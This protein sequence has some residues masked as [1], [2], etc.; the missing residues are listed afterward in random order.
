MATSTLSTLDP[1]LQDVYLGPLTE[2]F[3]NRTPLYDRVERVVPSQVFNGR[4]VVLASHTGRNQGFGYRPE[5]A[6]LPS[7]KRPDS[8]NMFVDLVYGYGKIKLSGQII[9]AT[10]KGRKAFADALEWNMRDIKE[11]LGF[12]TAKHVVF[13]DGTG[14]MALANGAGTSQTSLIVD[15]PGA[16]LFE[17]EMQ[18][19]V[20]TSGGSQEVNNVE[21]TA[22]NQSTDTLTLGTASTWSDN[23]K[24]YL[25]GERNEVIMGLAGIVD[26]GTR[27]SSFQGVTRSSNT[28]LN[29]NVLSNSGTNR[30]VTLRLVDDGAM[31]GTKNMASS[32]QMPTAIY[33][34][35]V[36]AQNYAELVRVD[37][38]F[39]PNVKT[40]NNGWRALEVEVPGGVLPWFLEPMCR[41]NE[42]F[43]VRES[44][45]FMLE[46]APMGWVDYDGHVTR[47]A[48]DGS[49]ALEACLRVY[50]QLA[51]R[52]CNTHTLIRDVTES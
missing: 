4:R 47:M 34:R 13:G 1:I 50:H 52:R 20:Y 24:V 14:V 40:L 44:D 7:A 9:A 28:W 42:I 22:I 39:S 46:M 49:D 45:L 31:E 27:V 19:D 23:S 38:R 16:E 32:G 33:S 17:R 37:R 36:I 15:N 2:Q 29:A 3:Y 35:P 12:H 5:G 25:H 43:M 30:A 6:A 48:Q 26:D 18:I 11:G 8:E 10:K 41:P 51:A 21:V